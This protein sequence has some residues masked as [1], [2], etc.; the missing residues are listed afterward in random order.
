MYHTEVGEK[1]QMREK[2]NRGNGNNAEVER[3]K[4]WRTCVE[5]SKLKEESRWERR[6]TTTR[7]LRT[8]REQHLFVLHGEKEDTCAGTWTKKK[9]PGQGRDREEGNIGVK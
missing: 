3:G 9:K 4:H 8:G 5:R 7:D 1:T 2:A 6:E